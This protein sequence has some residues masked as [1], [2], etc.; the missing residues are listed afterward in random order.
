MLKE[1]PKK[2]Y[3]RKYRPEANII[4]NNTEHISEY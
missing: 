1:I 3:E 2:K 4:V